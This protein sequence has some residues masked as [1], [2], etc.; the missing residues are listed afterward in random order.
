MAAGIRLRSFW[1][2]AVLACLIAVYFDVGEALPL[3]GGEGDPGHI[4]LLEED[5]SSSIME[6]LAEAERI[7]S[8]EEAYQQNSG[9]DAAALHELASKQLPPKQVNDAVGKAEQVSLLSGIA[10]SNRHKTP[11]VFDDM[12]AKWDKDKTQ[13]SQSTSASNAL[14]KADLGG[15]LE[16]NNDHKL[17][18]A[19]SSSSGGSVTLV[20]SLTS[21]ASKH[22]DNTDPLSA[23]QKEFSTSLDTPDEAA[24]TESK[25][26]VVEETVA[27]IGAEGHGDSKANDWMTN[28]LAEWGSEQD[29]GLMPGEEVTMPS[30]TSA[31]KVQENGE[32]DGDLGESADLGESDEVD[33]TAATAEKNLN[34]EI[35]QEAQDAASQVVKSTMRDVERDFLYTEKAITHQLGENAPKLTLE[36]LEKAGGKEKHKMVKAKAK[37]KHKEM[38]EKAQMN[39]ELAIANVHKEM[40]EQLANELSGLKIKLRETEDKHLAESKM[41]QQKAKEEMEVAVRD[42]TTKL[43]EKMKA[44]LPARLAGIK[45]KAESQARKVASMA[46][47]EI[48]QGAR[49]VRVRLQQDLGE[50]A[51]RVHAAQDRLAAS[52]KNPSAA[53]KS[54]VDLR[55][56]KSKYKHLHDLAESALIQQ[57]S[58]ASK[59]ILEAETNAK[60]SV[61]L[62]VKDAEKKELM[63]AQAEL[64]ESQKKAEAEEQKKLEERVK[65]IKS[66][67]ETKIKDER[68]KFK[69]LV[70]AAVK[71]AP[72]KEKKLRLK[73]KVM[74]HKAKVAAAAYEDQMMSSLAPHTVDGK[75][76]TKEMAAECVKNPSGCSLFTLKGHNVAAAAKFAESKA[77]KAKRA[78]KEAKEGVTKALEKLKVTTQVSQ[79]YAEEARSMDEKETRIRLA[80]LQ[81]NE[82]KAA[83]A[84]HSAA[85][86]H[87]QTQLVHAKMSADENDAGSKLKQFEDA[88]NEMKVTHDEKTLDDA[89]KAKQQKLTAFA[90]AQAAARAVLKLS[91]PK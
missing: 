66:L 45:E 34:S 71:M 22:D 58:K 85:K 72:S 12:L 76:V 28:A 8:G 37:K 40:Q 36:T 44:K 18:E 35:E 4:E 70:D 49:K 62:A 43:M 69:K 91:A 6:Q 15:Q 59:Q 32:H 9:S 82:A 31:S 17:V 57:K 63:T 11:S 84:F 56:E 88:L 20:S 51:G 2:L 23:F 54:A 55:T 5:A 16:A 89:A 83:A 80:K 24:T 90:K 42:K 53:L 29:A 27:K 14:L 86:A 81:L 75:T 30:K 64:G 46:I 68:S 87:L 50:A 79:K 7:G 25:S 73:A 3:R 78:Q 61:A 39:Y 52:D 1:G 74:L 21:A 41:L 33:S 26:P 47:K 13:V 10:T 77:R 65:K 38:V 67:A 60:E 19:L 48:T